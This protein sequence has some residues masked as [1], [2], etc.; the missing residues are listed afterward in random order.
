MNADFRVVDFNLI[1]D[2]AQVGATERDG[3]VCDVLAYKGREFADFLLG[4]SCFRPE[5]GGGAVLRRLRLIAVGF[6]RG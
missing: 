2:G 4:D 6:E 1:D 3:A 5:F